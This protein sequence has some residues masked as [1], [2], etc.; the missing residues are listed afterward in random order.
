MFALDDLFVHIS[1]T[2]LNKYFQ[3]RHINCETTSGFIA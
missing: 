1:T 3:A 2:M